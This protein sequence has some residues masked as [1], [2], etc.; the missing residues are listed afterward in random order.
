M[1]QQYFRAHVINRYILEA[2]L[3]K[4]HCCRKN[5][6]KLLGLVKG[7]TTIPLQGVKWLC[8]IPKSLT[9]QVA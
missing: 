6:S 3:E 8:L 1:L 4:G 2:I 9:V 7:K 5:H